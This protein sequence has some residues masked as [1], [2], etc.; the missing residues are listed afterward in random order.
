VCRLAHG[1]FRRLG[2]FL[3]SRMPCSFIASLS[4]LFAEPKSHLFPPFRAS[5]PSELALKASP[6]LLELFFFSRPVT[7]LVPL[8]LTRRRSVLPA[9]ALFFFP[10]PACSPSAQLGYHAASCGFSFRGICYPAFTLP[11]RAQLA[12]FPF[13][14]PECA[15]KVLYFFVSIGVL[16]ILRRAR[17]SRRSRPIPNRRPFLSH[18]IRLVLARLICVNFSCMCRLRASFSIECAPAFFQR[19][20]SSPLSYEGVFLLPFPGGAEGDSSFPSNNPKS[21]LLLM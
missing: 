5:K 3:P 11:R 21:R 2:F 14:P 16:P 20:K 10:Q 8:A 17:T 18:E 1:G 4:V 19:I 6:F 7:P 15:S 12:S 9:S 13:S